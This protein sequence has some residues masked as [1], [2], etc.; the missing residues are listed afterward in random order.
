MNEADPLNLDHTEAGQY[1]IRVQGHLDHRWAAWFD[2]LTL[3][4]EENGDTLISGRVM[5]QAALFGLLRGV[6]DAGMPLVSV[7]RV[8]AS[9]ADQSSD[10]SE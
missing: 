4:L 10:K 6:R 3:T 2:G 1:E 9:R 8:T 7:N 5:D